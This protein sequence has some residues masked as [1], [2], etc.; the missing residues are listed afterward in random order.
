VGKAA[1]PYIMKPIG[2]ACY[3]PP[4]LPA[5][6]WNNIL[7]LNGGRGYQNGASLYFSGSDFLKA[8]YGTI[9]TDANGT[10]TN[11]F[12]IEQ[13]AGYLTL[14]VALVK[15]TNDVTEVATLRCNLIPY[16]TK[17]SISG[18]VVL[19]GYG[20]GRGYWLN[21]QGQLDNNKYIQDSYFYQDYSYEIQANKTLDEYKSIFY[22]T[23]H[24]S[25]NELFGKYF[26]T[27]EEIKKARIIKESIEADTTPIGSLFRWDSTVITCDDIDVTFDRVS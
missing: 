7:I 6:T 23:F 9:L 25:G 27:Y 19:R 5:N 13:G 18:S 20:I 15:T 1:F 3:I 12:L 24:P 14:P 26:D 22:S 8:A 10:I 2:D 11:T 17:S 16:N 21:T 4:P